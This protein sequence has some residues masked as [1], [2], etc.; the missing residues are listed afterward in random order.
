MINE[1]AELIE[2]YEQ[3][4]WS[5]GDYFYRI[6]LL[7]P[8]FSIEELRDELPTSDRE[9]FVS[10]LREMYDNDVPADSFVSIGTPGDTALARARIDALRSWL[11]AHRGVDA[12]GS[13]P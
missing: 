1:L 4:A 13:P 11:R 2:L 10:W 3:G 12:A 7:V 9:D 6:T 5:R 8:D